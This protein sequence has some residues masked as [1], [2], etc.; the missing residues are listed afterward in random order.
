[1]ILNHLFTERAW[2]VYNTLC[3]TARE[4]GPATIESLLRGFELPVNPVV[5]EKALPYEEANRSIDHLEI[6]ARQLNLDAEQQLVPP[7]Y[8]LAPDSDT[9]PAVVVV[10][11]LNGRTKF[12]LLWRRHGSLLQ[13]MDPTEG[14][15]W[16][17]ADQFL[18]EIYSY[19]TAVSSQDW[20]DWARSP[21]FQ[22]YLSHKLQRLEFTEKDADTLLNEALSQDSWYALAA[23]DAA[24]R[25]I[26]TGIRTE[27]FTANQ[28]ARE[29]LKDL[30]D[31]A[32]QL[33]TSEWSEKAISYL[34]EIIP[35]PYWS[36]LPLPDEA[37]DP[38]E[39]ISETRHIL[40]RGAIVLR[41]SGPLDSSSEDPDALADDT[42]EQGIDIGH[43]DLVSEKT[44]EQVDRQL[45]NIL[46]KDGLFTSNVLLAGIIMAA[47]GVTIEV[48]LFQG[49]MQLGGYL[50]LFSQRIGAMVAIV[51][52]LVI[53]FILEM[54]I[55]STSLHLGRRLETRLRIAFLEKI[56]RLRSEYFYG[57]STADLVN[58]AYAIQQVRHV[59]N[60]A[61]DIIRLTFQALFIALGLIWL[62]GSNIVF[63]T[64]GLLS[65]ASLMYIFAPSIGKWSFQQRIQINKLLGVPLDAFLGSMPLTTHGAE[66]MLRRVY[67]SNLVPWMK[68]S[69]AYGQTITLAQTLVALVY[70]VFSVSV[71]FTYINQSGDIN[72]LL[73][74]TYW[75]LI[76]PDVL[77]KLA[78]VAIA[79][80]FQRAIATLV[81]EQIHAPEEFDD[82]V[83]TEK[84]SNADRPSDETAP[85]TAA[86]ISLNNVSVAI[87][88]NP[89]LQ[90]V[91]LHITS[92][93]HIGIVG[94]SG[95]GKST[96]VGLLLGFYQTTTGALHINGEPLNLE[97]LK[98]LRQQTAWVDP[99][100][101]LWDR[102]FLDNIE[103]GLEE[104]NSRPL[105]STI[106][107]ADLYK[108][109]QQLPDGL[110]S[111][112]GEAGG[113]IS[114]GEGQ[115]VRLGRAMMRQDI[116]LV[117]LDEPFRG[118]DRPKRRELLDRARQYWK[119]ATLICIT[120]DVGEIR[121][122][123]R[124][125]VVEDGRIVEDGS[126]E[127][128]ATEETSRYAEFLKAE[129]ATQEGLWAATN[130]RRLWLDEGTLQ[131]TNT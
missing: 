54:S 19:T 83:D 40:V 84:S 105:M 95:A 123:E 39:N 22:K 89:I 75:A 48:V 119:D 97:T 116:Q 33:D 20:I 5:L 59:P 2:L 85:V 91:D 66:Q 10:R 103:Y 96:L 120:H 16:V 32:K 51:A 122:F 57:R 107:Q 12:V 115:R 41:V 69:N 28:L 87:E 58:R 44:A 129:E 30:F 76:F 1:M 82:Q 38:N 112:L 121:A 114:G 99:G 62:N 21:E 3:P 27:I 34:N 45:W 7:D 13:I 14:R 60:I 124:V 72:N 78:T 52:F 4:S 108:L 80:P 94:P 35:L 43:P 11:Q 50:N 6:A 56:P 64:I 106:D 73:L 8:V 125:L 92:G 37:G 61:L 118:L 110:K 9:L 46:W 67:E 111:P 47:L 130:W 29:T 55:T 42:D 25:L 93:D 53:L 15:R 127:A 63:I 31:K 104:S 109:L 88:G 68:T 113:F 90:D 86:T 117:I 24:T 17:Q 71:I 65:M 101:Q 26:T 98:Q 100:I 79:Y 70:T 49:L 131:E 18:N 102:S 23:L 128:L 74:L 36:A 81:F 126:P 77:R